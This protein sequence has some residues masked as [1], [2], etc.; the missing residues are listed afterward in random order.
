MWN[1]ISIYSIT[2]LLITIAT[3]SFSTLSPKT[4]A[5]KLT[6]TC[7]ALNMANMV[8]GSVGDISAPKYS[9]SKKV[10]FN[11]PGKN[12]IATYISDPMSSAD[13]VVPIMA[14]VRIAP[15]LRK[16]YFYMA[17]EKT[18]I[19]RKNESFQKDYT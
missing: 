2:N 19:S 12:L 17:T 13:M 4:N 16:K 18:N 7:N 1:L 15:K 8:N 3:A 10:K 5:Y 14:N 6:S 11:L 9:V